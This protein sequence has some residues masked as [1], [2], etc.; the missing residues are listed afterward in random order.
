MAKKEA[1]K[2]SYGVG[3]YW[4]G[5]SGSV[6]LYCYHNEIFYGTLKDAKNFRKYVEK[7]DP[8]Q[9]YHIFMLTEVPE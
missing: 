8:T 3:H 9:K 4:E 5:E 2:F 7:K 6:A 1:K